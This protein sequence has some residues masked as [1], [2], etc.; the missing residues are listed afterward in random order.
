VLRR[1][2]PVAALAAGATVELSWSVRLPAGVRPAGLHLIAVVDAGETED[3]S[4]E[5]NNVAVAGPLR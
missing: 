2:S 1:E 3:E 4:D 5:S